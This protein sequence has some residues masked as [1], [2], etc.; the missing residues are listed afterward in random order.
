MD[1]GTMIGIIGVITGAV[2]AIVA[3]I[4]VKSAR[5]EQRRQDRDRAAVFLLAVADTL[6]TMVKVFRE[7]GRPPYSSGN[8][9]KKLL[10]VYDERM[11]PYFADQVQDDLRELQKL[12]HFA[13]ELDDDYD[14]TFKEKGAEIIGRRTGKQYSP[15]LEPDAEKQEEYL[16]HM[17]RMAGNL[18]GR[19]DEISTEPTVGP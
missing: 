8:R 2:S 10:K 4:Q 1:L 17:S 14:S 19:A 12:A 16:T 7:E 15:S 11:R 9:L 18:R 13:D 5:K 3:V 6:D